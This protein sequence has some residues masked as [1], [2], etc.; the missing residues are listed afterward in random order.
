MFHSTQTLTRMPTSTS[1]SICIRQPRH[2]PRNTAVTRLP[3]GSIPNIDPHIQPRFKAHRLPSLSRRTQ[4]PRRLDT[5]QPPDRC[6]PTL[7]TCFRLCQSRPCRLVI[8]ALQ[9]YHNRMGALDDPR[10][11]YAKATLTMYLEDYHE[12]YTM[13]SPATQIKVSTAR[14]AQRE[15]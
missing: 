12:L 1:S 15:S 9:V 10:S 7:P 4:P 11:L 14:P 5:P 6:Q 8:P 13:L 3:I 2:L